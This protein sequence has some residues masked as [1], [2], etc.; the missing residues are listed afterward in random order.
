MV[1]SSLL[2]KVQGASDIDPCPFLMQIESHV[3]RLDEDLNQFAEDLK[4]GIQLYVI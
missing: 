3:K 4:Q 2:F 1:I